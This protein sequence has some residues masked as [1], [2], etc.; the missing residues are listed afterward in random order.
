MMYFRS[1]TWFSYDW[2][3]STG[4]TGTAGVTAPS[5]LGIGGGAPTARVDPGNVLS[6]KSVQTNPKR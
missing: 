4:G 2:Q 1:D 5:G 3:P 6:Y